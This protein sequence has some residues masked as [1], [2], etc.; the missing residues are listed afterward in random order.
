M[1]NLYDAPFLN[2][3]PAVK[4]KPLE[5][6]EVLAAIR[7]PYFNR[8]L[9]HYSSHRNTPFKL[10]NADHSAVI[11]K[12]NIIYIASNLAEMYNDNGAKVHR[13]L[14][15]NVLNLL[16]TEP[17]LKVELQSSGRTNLLYQPEK[18]RYV[19]HLLYGSPIS[20][21]DAQVIEDLVPIYNTKVV[22]NVSERIKSV[23][24]IPENISLEFSKTEE[25]VFITV[26]EFT[27]HTAVVFEY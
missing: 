8:T 24:L 18:N 26:P 13:D 17:M 4:V 15:N 23:R 20:R 1:H 9:S 3:S 5:G 16:H 27:C 25:G 21:G 12:G 6:T 10:E 19:A 14:F 2:Y 22:L 7:E 11:K